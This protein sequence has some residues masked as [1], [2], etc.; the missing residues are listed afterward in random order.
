MMYLVRLIDRTLRPVGEVNGVGSVEISTEMLATDPEV[1]I[2]DVN[3]SFAVGLQTG[4][5]EFS[6]QESQ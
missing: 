5:Q 2:V 4:W 3:E 6:R 1:G